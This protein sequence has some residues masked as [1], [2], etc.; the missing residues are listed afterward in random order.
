M[1]IPV[2]PRITMDGQTCRCLEDKRGTLMECLSAI[3]EQGHTTAH[4]WTRHRQGRRVYMVQG[5]TWVEVAR[6]EPRTAQVREV[7]V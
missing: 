1:I 2:G 4:L 5:G 3:R 6:C 7:D